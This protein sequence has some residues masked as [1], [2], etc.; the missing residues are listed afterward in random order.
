[1]RR[2]GPRLPERLPVE[3]RD[4]AFFQPENVQKRWQFQHSGFCQP[5]GSILLICFS[6]RVGKLC[7][8][9]V[10]PEG[11]SAR[12]LGALFSTNRISD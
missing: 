5:P 12:I 8:L 1:M 11:F 10:K 2:L 6:N 3:T 7:Q 4:T 9:L